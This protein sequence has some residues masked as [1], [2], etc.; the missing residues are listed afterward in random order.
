MILSFSEKTI[1]QKDIFLQPYHIQSI[2]QTMF[3]AG[4]K[5][6]KFVVWVAVSSDLIRSDFPAIRLARMNCFQ[7]PDMRMTRSSGCCGASL[8]GMRK[9]C[10]SSLASRTDLNSGWETAA[11][12]HDYVVRY[13]VRELVALSTS[14]RVSDVEGGD[15]D[16]A[17][18]DAFLSLDGDI[19]DLGA[20][21]AS[22]PSFLND[23]MTQ[24][25]P[26]YAGSCALV[27]YYHSDSQQL[28]VACAGDSRAVLGRRK[29]SGGWEAIALS[30]DQTGNNEDEVSRLQKEHPDE[31]E[32]IKTGRLLG[33]AVTRAFGDSRWKWS[34]KT[35]DQ[36]HDRFYGPRIRDN[37]LTPPY[38]T[39]EPVITTTKIQPEKGDFVIMASDGL[40]DNLTSEQA[41]T[42]MGKWLEKHDPSKA[43]TPPDLAASPVT[44]PNR[45]VSVRQNPDSNKAYSEEPPADE[46]H[47]IVADENAATHL[48]RNALGGGNEDRL[49]G[50]LTPSPPY[51]RNIR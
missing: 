41:V 29:A 1:S 17:I 42:L 2:M 47:F 46:R 9:S 3:C 40:W 13:I 14:G 27:S 31:P 15:I 51:S 23:A 16:R 12:L 4:K 21:A 28:K 6:P 18:K 48:V 30:A 25:A 26:C 22:G 8:T 39:A 50:M 34:R 38:L 45:H 32:M 49:C 5:I 7:P 44:P 37:F 43:I 19:M 33:L 11:A 36:A 35:Q 10:R 24:V 20:K